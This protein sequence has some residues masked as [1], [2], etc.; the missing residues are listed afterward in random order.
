MENTMLRKMKDDWEEFFFGNDNGEKELFESVTDMEANS[1]WIPGISSRDIRLEAIDGRPMFIQD[2]MRKYHLDDE[3]LVDETANLGTDLLIYT[4][5]PTSSAAFRTHELVRNTAMDG[6]Y[7]VAKLNGAALGRMTRSKYCECMNAAFEVARGTSLGLMRYGKLSGLQSGADGGYMIMPISKLMDISAESLSG[8]FGDIELRT[9]YNT[10]GLTYAVWLL[11]DAQNRL[12]EMYQDAIIR[13]GLDSQYPINFMPAALFQSSDTKSSCAIL[14][15]CFILPSGASLRFAEGVRIKHLRRSGRSEGIDLFAAEASNI[16]AKFEASV[17]AIAE[18]SGIK[19]YNAENCLVGLCN[20]YGIS[21]K[22]GD[23][24]REEVSRISCGETYISA[25]DLYI[26]MSECIAEA[27]RSN[28][29]ATVVNK[30]EESLM[31]IV[32]IRDFSEFDV[33]GLVSW[34]NSQAAA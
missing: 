1:Q 30:I 29:K 10:H 24:A 22:Y 25:H 16:F 32:Q 15:P 11:P 34:N 12:I 4:G 6:I 33:G 20:K 3:D 9:G 18:L 7:A 31:K 21:K 5:V 2:E 17:D 28:A 14:D 13:S 19:I 8:R 27:E 23:A 26:A